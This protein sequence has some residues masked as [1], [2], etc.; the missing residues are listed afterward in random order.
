M[1]GTERRCWHISI[2]GVNYLLPEIASH[3]ATDGDGQLLGV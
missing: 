2:T 3:L 1:Q